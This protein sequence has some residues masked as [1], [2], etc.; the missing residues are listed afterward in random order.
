MVRTRSEV[1][2]NPTVMDLKQQARSR[3]NQ[4]WLAFYET[5]RNAIRTGEVKDYFASHTVEDEEELDKMR[6]FIRLLSGF[7]FEQHIP[8]NREIPIVTLLLRELD[9]SLGRMAYPGTSEALISDCAEEEVKRY[10]VGRRALVCSYVEKLQAFREGVTIQERGWT[11]GLYIYR[12]MALS[13]FREHLDTVTYLLFLS[14][15]NLGH[16]VQA[17]TNWAKE[18]VLPV[19]EM[20]NTAFSDDGVS[21]PVLFQDFPEAGETFLSFHDSAADNVPELGHPE[22]GQQQGPKEEK[23]EGAEAFVPGLSSTREGKY[24]AFRRK[25]RRTAAANVESCLGKRKLDSPA[26][27]VYDE[28]PNEGVCGRRG[29]G[30]AITSRSNGT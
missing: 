19:I 24:N 6:L 25:E 22:V 28:Q 23:P 20:L 16:A 12:A 8:V 17:H 3:R 30:H 4:E 15:E 18:S 5:L 7:P 29:H 11:K 2:D 26:K 13:L 1:R 10:M 9:K 27:G 14:G 21:V